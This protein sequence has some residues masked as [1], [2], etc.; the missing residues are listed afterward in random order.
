MRAKERDTLALIVKIVPAHQVYQA[1]AKRHKPALIG[2][3]VTQLKKAAMP[4]S[5]KKALALETRTPIHHAASVV[6]SNK[7]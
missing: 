1:K 2:L 6:V 4:A 3:K 5:L 7:Q